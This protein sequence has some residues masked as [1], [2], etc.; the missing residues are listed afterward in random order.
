M[1]YPIPERLR[2]RLFV[3]AL[4]LTVIGWLIMASRPLRPASIV[5]FEFANN[6]QRA[7]GI[8]DGWRAASGDGV[9]YLDH[10]RFSLA[11]DNIWIPCYTT[12]L[13]LACMWASGRLRR[14]RA[15]AF[16]GVVLA[17]GAWAAGIFDWIEN[18][19][20]G[21]VLAILTGPN[22]GAVPPLL[23]LTPYIAATSAAIKFVLV[24]A[25]LVY[26]LAGA[27]AWGWGRVRERTV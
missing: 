22:T 8:I 1:R 3:V 24:G 25:G 9:D 11:V 17:W 27:A 18:W 26:V 13:S 4:V 15:L 12:A 2:G 20:L 23:T 6:W 7:Q 21:Q 19:A 14:P 5:E 10:A 16:F